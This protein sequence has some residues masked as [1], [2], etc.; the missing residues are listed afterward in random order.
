MGSLTGATRQ[1]GP[2]PATIFTVGHSTRTL[3]EFL[4]LLRAHAVR[5]IANVRRFPGSRRLPHFNAASLAAALPKAGIRYLP[6]PALGGRRRPAPDSPNAGWRNES[7]RGYADYLRT[8]EFREA[9]D[10]LCAAA[11]QEPTA[12]MCAEA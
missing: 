5:A 11:G 8:P 1:D 12:M 2:G 4:D 3:E 10:K 7:F 9:L 6:F